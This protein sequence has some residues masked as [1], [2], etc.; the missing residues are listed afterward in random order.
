MRTWK[1]FRSNTQ[2]GD[3]LVLCAGFKAQGSEIALSDNMRYG[4][5]TLV[6]FRR[7]ARL[8]RMVGQAPFFPS[9]NA[10]AALLGAFEPGAPIYSLAKVS[11]PATASTRRERTPQRRR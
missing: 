4:D 5:E 6:K 2:R 9:L 7:V 11:P 3:P 10:W 8:I 1:I